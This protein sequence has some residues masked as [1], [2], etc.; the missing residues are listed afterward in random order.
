M[1]RAATIYSVRNG[2]DQE[3]FWT[4]RRAEA[5]DMREKLQENNPVVVKRYGD[6]YVA[7]LVRLVDVSDVR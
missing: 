5:F 2:I 3:V 1:T 7:R 6:Y 4:T